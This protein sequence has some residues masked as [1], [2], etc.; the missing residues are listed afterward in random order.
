MGLAAS[1]GSSVSPLEIVRID[2]G[3]RKHTN[4][5][6]IDTIAAAA[7]DWSPPEH[8]YFT[9][10]KGRCIHNM[11]VLLP[12]FEAHRKYP[13][14]VFIDGGAASN[15]PDQISLRWNYHLLAASGRPN[16]DLT[17]RS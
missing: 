12:A 14:L 4:L 9:S 5:T 15:N 11:I 16:P 8:F 7:I 17:R 1:Y 10:G 2:P 13:L 3:S 6:N